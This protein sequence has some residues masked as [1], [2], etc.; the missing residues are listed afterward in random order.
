VGMN[1]ALF[2]K[3]LFIKANKKHEKEERDEKR[4]KDF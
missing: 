1:Y 3:K 4:E 2:L